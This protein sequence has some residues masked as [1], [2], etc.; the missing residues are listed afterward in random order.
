MSPTA[1]HARYLEQIDQ[2]AEA[3]TLT[4]ESAQ[5]RY[6]GA[7]LEVSARAVRAAGKFACREVELELERRE[8][9]RPGC[10]RR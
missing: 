3:L 9:V 4:I 2:A 10:C 1:D 7:Q 5:L 8:R 6:P